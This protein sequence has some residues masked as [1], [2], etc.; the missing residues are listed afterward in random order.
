MGCPC[1]EAPY[2][3]KINL[4]YLDVLHQ[5]SAME[6]E[7]AIINEVAY[8]HPTEADL[9]KQALVGDNLSVNRIFLYLS[10]A[11]PKLRQIM[12]ESIHDAAEESLWQH[13]L[14]CLATHYW[15]EGQRTDRSLDQEASQ[16]VD[17]TIAEVFAQDEYT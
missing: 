15:E 7:M 9:L 12:Q 5:A 16:R 3:Q 10:S 1:L 2:H 14:R 17:Q 4:L 13:L 8:R 11:N 6:V